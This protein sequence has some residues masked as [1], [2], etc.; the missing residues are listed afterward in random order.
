MSVTVKNVGPIGELEI[1]VPENGGCVV[2]RGHNGSGKS[3]ALDAIRTAAGGKG[4]LSARDGSDRGTVTAFGATITIAASQRRRGVAEVQSLEG[5]GDVSDLVDPQ[6]ADDAKADAARIRTMVALSGRQLSGADFAEIVTA[7]LRDQIAAITADDPLEVAGKVKRRIEEAARQHEQQAQAAAA[8]AA[9]C[10]AQ[11]QGI[12]LTA[13][14]DANELTEAYA[15]AR[16]MVAALEAA[17]GPAK[18][19]AQQAREAAAKLAEME[20]LEELRE[21]MAKAE[22]ESA[23]VRAGVETTIAR[24][25]ALE[26]KIAEAQAALEVDRQFVA[27]RQQMLTTYAESRKRAEAQI[28][29]R[30]QLEATAAQPMELIDDAK[31]T[32]ARQAAIEAQAA[33]TRGNQVREAITRAEA[34]REYERGA[35]AQKV[36]AAAMRTAAGRVDEVLSGVVSDLCA[37]IRIEDGRLVVDTARGRTLFAELSHGERWRLALDY[38]IAVVGRGG[39]L[40]C[41]QEAWEGLDPAN[42]QAV[43]Q[44]LH[45]SGVVM[46]TAAADSGDIVAEVL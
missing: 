32:A 1:P 43:A 42:R 30:Q 18:R 41:P 2:L 33:I 11:N 16:G 45:G 46:F 36:Y 35:A 38:A 7:E 4:K 23:H 28:Q 17:V 19:A 6:I 21:S 15:A 27:E 37:A 8:L 44:Q 3:T 20:T 9:S 24:I 14:H 12:D 39:V 34:M 10:A 26:Q 40:V 31:L 29:L 22:K 25:A 13:P 5:R